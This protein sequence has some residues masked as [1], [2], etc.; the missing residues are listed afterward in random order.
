MEEFSE[1]SV[2]STAAQ[3][4]EVGKY[5]DPLQCLEENERLAA[6][7][8]IEKQDAVHPLPTYPRS[9]ASADI[10]LVFKKRC[11]PWDWP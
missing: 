6:R 8:Q 3:A 1:A 5:A 11:L 10:F 9:G 7:A 4:T 2:Q